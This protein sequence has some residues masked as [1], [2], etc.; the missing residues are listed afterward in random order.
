VEGQLVNFDSPQDSA[1]AGISTVYQ[2]M[3]LIPGLTVAE[4]VT[5]GVWPTRRFAGIRVINSGALQEL[6]GE[7]VGRLGINIPLSAVVADLTMAERQMVEIAKGLVHHPRLL[8]LDEPTSS[9]CFEEVDALLGVVKKLS[10]AGVAVI[11][12]SH[13]M[14]EIPRIADTVTVL[15]D[16]Q[17]VET[18]G[19]QDATT[20]RVTALMVGDE[21]SSMDTDAGNQMQ[22][23]VEFNDVVPALE[24]RRLVVPGRVDNVS[25]EVKPGEIVGLAGLLGSGRTEILRSIYGTQPGSRGEVFVGGIKLEKRS[26]RVMLRRG[27]GLT[28]EDR[29]GEGL[30]LQLS[31]AENLVMSSGPSIAT[32][33][34]R[35]SSRIRQLVESMIKRLAVKTD[36]VSTS[37]SSLSGGNQQK[38]VIGKALNAGVKVLLLDEPTRGIDVRAK[39]QVYGLMAEL[40]SQG[41]A[42]LFVSSELEELP[43]HTHRILVLRHGSVVFEADGLTTGVKELLN[44]SMGESS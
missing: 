41:M 34:V 2:E 5:L 17:L 11:Y 13:R 4:N 40:A 24:V 16:G 7:A 28:P 39:S 3:S 29:A 19:I 25:F 22:N 30:V 15:R 12:V 1:A 21:A 8:I 9:L 6:A 33:G 44:A 31:V 32:A 42:I 37:A 18:L 23:R 36:R 38:L 26:P 10:S 43:G 20:A 14:D 35:R 27:V